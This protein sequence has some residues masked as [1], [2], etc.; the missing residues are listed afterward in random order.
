MLGVHGSG[1]IAGENSQK[2]ARIICGTVLAGE[3]SLLAALASNHLVKS[4]LKLNRTPMKLQ[5]IVNSTTTLND[6]VSEK[7]KN[8][9]L[10]TVNSCPLL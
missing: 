2:L 6:N 5:N 8:E 10:N 7:E 3:L 4:H 9:I 1:D